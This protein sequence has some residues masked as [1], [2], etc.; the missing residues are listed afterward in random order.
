MAEVRLNE[1]VK[2][3]S[4]DS[5]GAGLDWNSPGTQKVVLWDVGPQKPVQPKKPEVPQGKNGDPAFDLA[6]IDFEDAAAEYK[7]ALEQYRRE[8]RDHKAWHDRYGG[9][10]EMHGVWSCD[11]DDH[12]AR[13][14]KRY[15]VSSSTR[16]HSGRPNRGLPD[17]MKPGP[18]HHENIRRIA[19]GESD[20]LAM[21]QADP[22]FG[23]QELRS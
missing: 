5:P 8:V 21:K 4:S 3:S 12:M 20:M 19:Q 17:G 18:W 23:N 1:H 16:G 14:P 2:L 22:I 10:Y 7:T 9:P 13:D 11:A 6:R 15:F